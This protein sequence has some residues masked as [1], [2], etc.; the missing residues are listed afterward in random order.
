[1]IFDN[2]VHTRHDTKTDEIRRIFL[3]DD[4]IRKRAIQDDG[5]WKVQ[6]QDVLK[7]KIDRQKKL[8]CTFSLDNIGKY[9]IVGSRVH[10][11]TYYWSDSERDWTDDL[12]HGTVQA[13]EATATVEAGNVEHD[14]EAAAVADTDAVEATGE[15]WEEAANAEH[16]HEAANVEHDHGADEQGATIDVVAQPQSTNAKKWGV[17][18]RVIPEDAEKRILLLLSTMNEIE[19]T[20]VAFNFKFTIYEREFLQIKLHDGTCVKV[21]L[22][23]RLVCESKFLAR[24]HSQTLPGQPGQA[25]CGALR[26][27]SSKCPAL[28]AEIKDLVPWLHENKIRLNVV[29]I[30]NEANL[31]DAPSHQRGLDMWSCSSPCNK[32]SC[33]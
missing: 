24:S 32:S 29:Y 28:M 11:G 10:I 1:M 4:D 22:D 8:N 33:T 17:L 2:V 13:V 9:T 23:P 27:M 30:R 19:R 7:Q 21:P 31:A 25:V 26:K 20:D 6:R 14:R 5:T 12:D 16:D 18:P 15:D 3:H